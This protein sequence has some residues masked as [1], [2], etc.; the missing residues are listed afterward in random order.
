MIHRKGERMMDE[1]VT[2]RLRL[3][4]PKGLRDHNN[5]VTWKW[6]THVYVAEDLPP[7]DG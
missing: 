7:K 3:K 2:N 4:T 5:G 1:S 6:T